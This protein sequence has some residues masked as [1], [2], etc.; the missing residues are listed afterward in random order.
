MQAAV[1]VARDWDRIRQL[2]AALKSDGCTVVT[3]AF[4]D[5][6]LLHDILY[7]T[8]IDPDTGQPVSRAEA[9]RTFRDCMQSRSRLGRFSPMSWWRYLG[10]RL[11]GRFF[12]QE[13]R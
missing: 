10:V 2:A 3:E 1:G 7:K 8:G 9:D 5:C 11:F 4:L 12:R 6:C 13:S